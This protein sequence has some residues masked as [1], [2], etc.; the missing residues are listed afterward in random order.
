MIQVDER[1]I[2]TVFT[3]IGIVRTK[4]DDMKNDVG[5]ITV[6]EIKDILSVLDVIGNIIASE[7]ACAGYS[8]DRILTEAY[9]ELNVLM[10][11]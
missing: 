11:S 7:M 5:T 6:L 4:L 3:T 2:M 9:K 10:P 8:P 1:N